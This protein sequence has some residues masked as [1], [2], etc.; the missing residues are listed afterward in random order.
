MSGHGHVTPNPDGSRARCGGPGIC[1]ECSAEYGQA[2]NVKV[3][4]GGQSTIEIRC[5][6]CKS[7]I[8]ETVKVVRIFLHDGR[9][10][11]RFAP[12]AYCGSDSWIKLGMQGKVFTQNGI[13][14]VG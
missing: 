10:E 8:Q 9:R 5:P 14:K 6:D 13:E 2:N 3:K 1:V 4:V 12:C 11:D 7:K